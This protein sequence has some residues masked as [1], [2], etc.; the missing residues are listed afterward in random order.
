MEKEIEISKEHL[1]NPNV[2]FD[3]NEEFLIYSSLT[4]IKFYSISK[5]QL[6][7]VIGKHENEIFLKLALYQGKQM[8]NPSG[9]A[10]SEG[11]RRRADPTIYATAF[12]KHRFYIFSKSKPEETPDGVLLRDVFNEV[13]NKEDI[14]ANSQSKPLE[15]SE[16]IIQTTF[17]D[18]HVKLFT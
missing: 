16:V 13:P 18:I 15:I 9:G 7:K 2:E 4:G 12:K 1:V 11:E 14:Q 6:I 8:R 10:T 3:E 17:G 5:R